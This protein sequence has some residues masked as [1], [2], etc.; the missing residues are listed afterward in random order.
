[1]RQISTT[2]MAVPGRMCE[3]SVGKTLQINSAGVPL[4]RH[5]LLKRKLEI[6]KVH[7][8]FY[9]TVCKKDFFIF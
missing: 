4:Y 5:L 2:G 9:S 7:S 3:I 6:F 1:M 8:D